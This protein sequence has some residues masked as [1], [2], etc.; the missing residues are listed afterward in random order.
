MDTSSEGTENVFVLTRQHTK[1]N[2]LKSNVIN[3]KH[4]HL[5]LMKIE[6]S[7]FSFVS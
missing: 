2:Q 7:S 6:Q 1:K 4:K 3:V 5:S